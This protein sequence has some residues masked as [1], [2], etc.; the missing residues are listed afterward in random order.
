MLVVHRCRHLFSILATLGLTS[1]GCFPDVDPDITGECV[2]VA[3]LDCRA[4]GYERDD[5]TGDPVLQDTGLVGYSCTGTARPDFD[6]TMDE[7][8]P[9]GLLCADRSGDTAGAGGASS[10][11]PAE[12][13]CTE[14][15]VD[16]AYDPTGDCDAP[17]YGV[18]CRGTNRPESL[19]PTL[20]CSNGTRDGEVVNYCCSGTHLP[21]P[22]QQSDA[23]GCSERML[24]FL[25][26]GEAL[27]RGEDLG[28]NKSR[29]DYYHPLCSIPEPAPNPDLNMYC[30]FMPAPV[31]EGG[32]CVNHASVPNCQPRQFG[33]A[34][35][36][37]DRPE[38]D[39]YPVVCSEA[40][41]EYYS[42]EGYPA[43]L[44]CCDFE[45]DVAD[46]P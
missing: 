46:A 17:A 1:A 8:V 42:D 14:E 40:P 31:P 11:G 26:E 30:C 35:Y 28:A 33:F 3:D 43:T 4:P 23:L 41:Y 21:S 6:A 13:C 27:P 2:V 25:C 15:K 9:R 5:E 24:G 22:C 39:N 20:Y 10:E 44:Y 32:T 37:P 38:D 12:F 29:A 45:D 36:G 34:C 19:N 16:C 18:Q 7:G